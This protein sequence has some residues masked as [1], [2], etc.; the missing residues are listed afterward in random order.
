MKT[1][2]LTIKLIAKKPKNVSNCESRAKEASRLN[3]LLAA[4]EQ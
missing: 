3:N 4:Q 1:R 2:G